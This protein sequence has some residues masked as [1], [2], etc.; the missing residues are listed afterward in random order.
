MLY[1]RIKKWGEVIVV[2]ALLLAFTGCGAV[3]V[4]DLSSPKETIQGEPQEIAGVIDPELEEILKSTPAEEELPVIVTLKKITGSNAS[5][6]KSF[7]KSRLVR[8]IHSLWIIGGMALKA[9]PATIRELAT[10]PDVESIRLDATLAAPQPL[11]AGG[12]GAPDGWNLSDIRATDFWAMGHTGTGVVVATMDTGVDVDHPDLTARWRGG[13]NSWFDPNG[14]HATPFDAAGHGTSVMGIIVGGDS[15]GAPIGVAPGAQWIA[16]K[17]FDD[18]GFTTY[19]KIH[20]GFQWLLDPDGNPAT[21]D[22][23]DVVNNSWGL[24]E[25]VNDCVTEFEPDIAALKAAGIVLSF[26]AGNEG[27]Y[28]AS[29]IS[30]AN[31]AEGFAIGA[32][33]DTRTIASFSSRGP[34]ACNARTYPEI[35]APG[36]NVKTADLTLGGTFP[37]SYTYLSGT[38]FA[39][40]HVAG[41]MALILSAD[42][43]ATVSEL[44]SALK[45]GAVPLGAGGKDNNYG[46]G[47]LDVVGAHDML[48][49]PPDCADADSD[50]YF[51]D[52]VCRTE[53]DCNDTEASI[54]PNATEI[55]HDAVDQDCNGFDLTIDVV[56]SGYSFTL[57]RLK[58][59]ASSE[60]G[61]GANLELLGYG[62][63]T[64]NAAS[65]KWEKNVGSV[66]RFPRRVIVTGPEGSQSSL[67]RVSRRSF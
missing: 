10:R 56:N 9:D 19:S 58:V 64:W 55:K 50:G 35:V 27:P 34:S 22:K 14:E 66:M 48:V 13:A 31:Y 24:R 7:L 47:L 52:A 46:Y 29:S 33:D 38:S 16:V 43:L 8:E 39:S 20:L 40:A 5:V 63:M 41:A 32:T 4:N 59:E 6:V 25:F 23:P 30:P 49:A 36:V 17:I 21:D 1:Q 61:G 15:S 26:S 45:Y 54:H 2:F 44:E 42:P 11:A 67:T 51:I 57:R 28:P 12:A 37:D 3:A 65:S 53:T 60:L 18:A 62:P